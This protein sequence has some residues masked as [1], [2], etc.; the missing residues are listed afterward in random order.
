MESLK[1]LYA[2]L[3]LKVNESKSRITRATTSQFLGYSFWVAKG[4][5]IRHRVGAK[6]LKAMKE[7]VRR[8]TARNGGRSLS[9]VAQE[10]RDYLPG[11]KEYFQLADTPSVFA[12]LDEWL[13]RRLRAVQPK[14]WKRPKTIRRELAARGVTPETAD[15]VAGC[16]RRWWR[17]SGTNALNVALPKAYF[18]KLGVPCLAG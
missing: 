6:A 13:R 4:R 1:R 9:H 5:Q 14:Q 3:K 7:R 15:S 12:Q 17:L 2:K 8:I 16:Y 11:W 10:L 18:T